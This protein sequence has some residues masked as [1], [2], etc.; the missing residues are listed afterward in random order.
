[1]VA[2]RRKTEKYVTDAVLQ[3]IMSSNRVQMYHNLSDF[4]V[5]V[6]VLLLSLTWSCCYSF[7]TDFL[8]FCINLT[9]Y[10]WNYIL[11]HFC[12]TS[13]SKHI[14]LK[15]KKYNEIELHKLWKSWSKPTKIWLGKLIF[16][17]KFY[18]IIPLWKL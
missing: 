6:F 9:L 7:R 2:S 8:T 5:F 15:N 13:V 16:I 4:Y 18:H 11:L 12:F 3:H 1:M 10:N 17:I 14:F